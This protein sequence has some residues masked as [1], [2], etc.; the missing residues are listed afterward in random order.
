MRLLWWL[1]QYRMPAVKETQVWSLCPS[2][3]NFLFFSFLNNVAFLY[4]LRIGLEVS[5]LSQ[6]FFSVSWFIVYGNLKGIG[7][8]LLCENCVNLN[9]VKLVHSAFQAKCILM[10]LCILILLIFNSLILKLQL[11]IFIYL[12]IIVIYSGSIC[13][14]VVYSPSLL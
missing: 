7:V 1:R 13:N 5:S 9:Y 6:N 12:K 10:L 11:K 8:L 14:F 4:S 2:H 3:I